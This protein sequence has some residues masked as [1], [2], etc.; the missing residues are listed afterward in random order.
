MVRFDKQGPDIPLFV[1]LTLI[2]KSLKTSLKCNGVKSSKNKSPK[3]G[4]LF[5]SGQTHNSKVLHSLY[6]TLNTYK[7]S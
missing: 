2:R 3:Q 5:I 1:T 6:A 4:N 7:S